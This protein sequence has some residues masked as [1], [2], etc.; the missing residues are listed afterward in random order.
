MATPF[1]APLQAP[2]PNSARGHSRWGACSEWTPLSL[3][4]PNLPQ[5]KQSHLNTTSLAT[6]SIPS[7]KACGAEAVLLRLMTAT[8]VAGAAQ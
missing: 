3:P 6:K 4:Q 7:V 8:P 1:A 5:Y 2:T